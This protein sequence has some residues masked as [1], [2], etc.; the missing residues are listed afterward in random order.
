MIVVYNKRKNGSVRW[1]QIKFC[2]G[3]TKMH[4]VSTDIAQSD[5]NLNPK[6]CADLTHPRAPKTKYK[7]IL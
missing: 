3:L 1:F 4:T 6:G 2:T 5:K 7:S